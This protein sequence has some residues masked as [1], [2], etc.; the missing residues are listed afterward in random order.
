[1]FI[2]DKH[3]EVRN[4]YNVVPQY[5]EVTYIDIVNMYDQVHI[6]T[7]VFVDTCLVR[8]LMDFIWFDYKSNHSH[9]YVGKPRNEF[10]R[11]IIKPLKRRWIEM[12]TLIAILASVPN[13]NN[14][15]HVDHITFSSDNRAENLKWSPYKPYKLKHGSLPYPDDVDKCVNTAITWHF[16]CFKVSH[17]LLRKKSWKTSKSCTNQ[18]KLDQAIK[19][20]E[21]L[22]ALKTCPK[23]DEEY[24]KFIELIDEYESM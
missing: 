11:N 1:M 4:R 7:K 6:S 21:E 9:Y 5:P 14:Y 13:P 8:K 12:H 2:D 16:D 18:Q 3:G 15:S 24:E 20:Y 22:T 23:S 10:A 19:K 17:P